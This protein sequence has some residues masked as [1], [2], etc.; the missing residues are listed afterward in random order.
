MGDKKEHRIGE[1]RLN[2]QSCLMKIITYNNANDIIVEFQDEYKGKVHT[3][4]SHFLSGGVKNPYYPNVYRFGITGNKYAIRENGRQTKEYI[5]WCNMLKRCFDE[6]LKNT[7]KTYE[8]VTC[9][10]EWLLFENFYE[11]LHS[12]ENFDKWLSGYRWDIDKDI[13]IKGNKIYSPE[14]CCLVPNRVNKL[15]V[16]Q[17]RKRGLLPIGIVKTKCGFQVF[18]QNPFTN[19]QE[20]LGTYTNSVK[21]FCV[22]KIHKED[23]I[24]QVAK[25]EYAKNNI[26]KVCYE[27]MLNY[28]VEITD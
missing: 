28:E 6:E 2:N 25:I 11:W 20:P 22:Y 13:L 14:T 18:C 16:K 3:R 26:T 4:Y 9:C 8:N 12:Q 24:K 19:K 27:A 23:F 1:E 7:Y 21:A 5:S 17:D 10:E 15:F